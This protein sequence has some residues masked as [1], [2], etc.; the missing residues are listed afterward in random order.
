MKDWV[1]T[2]PEF[3]Y[4]LGSDGFGTV[5]ATGDTVSPFKEGDERLRDGTPAG[6][7]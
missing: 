1:E 2:G 7:G 5:V 4:V 3:P 6:R